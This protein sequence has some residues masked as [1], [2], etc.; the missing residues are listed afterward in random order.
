MSNLARIW[1]KRTLWGL[2]FSVPGLILFG[3]VAISI[4]IGVLVAD[5]Q[6]KKNAITG[7][8]MSDVGAEEIP[9]DYIEIYQAA[10]KK[11]GVPW[12]LLA[13][14]HKVETN[15]SVDLNVS[16]AG[17]IGPMQFMP[18]T[19]LGW[20]YP[21]GSRLGNASIPDAIISSPK[22][23][24]KYGGYGVDGD[25]DGKAD[26][27]NLTDSVFAAANY[28]AANG[29]ANGNYQQAVF[30][31]NHSDQYVNAVLDWF[32]KYTKNKDALLSGGY[33]VVGG[34]KIIERA[35]QTGMTILNKSPYNWGGGRTQAD[36]DARSFDC[37]SFVR[38]AFSGADVDLG[39]IAST[40][41][42]TLVIKGKAVSV[43]KMERGDLLFFDTY[44]RNGHVGIYLGNGKFLNDNSSHG[45]S[46]DS[47]DNSYWKGVF[48]GT[49]RRIIIK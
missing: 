26:P 2:V 18:L 45:V 11:Y 3:V 7:A 47:L 38:W 42:D 13:A 44:K 22:M 25:G 39:P 16:S 40:T 31:Y 9:K 29:A 46:I 37:S 8:E 35:I 14:H 34:N 48:H 5:D 21:G 4:I 17:A 30:A 10:E 24:A 43:M 23:I 1:L 36:I 49:V 12:T 28:L 32:D 33:T 41:T 15:F 27:W 19:W 20:N 6:A